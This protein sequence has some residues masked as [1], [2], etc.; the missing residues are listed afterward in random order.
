MENLTLE[1]ALEMVSVHDP[2]QWENEEGP[3]G[4]FAVSH[5]DYGII[6]YF[7]DEKA[8]FHY[9]LMLINQMLNTGPLGEFRARRA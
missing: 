1:N 7:C 5:D 6:A 8:A 2:G 3:E 4:W 9:R